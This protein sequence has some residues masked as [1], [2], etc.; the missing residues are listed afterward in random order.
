MENRIEQGLRL[1]TA[2]GE[3]AVFRCPRAELSSQHAD[4]TADG[5]AA[6]RNQQSQGVFLGTAEGAT[7]AKATL[8]GAQHLTQVGE[9][10]HRS[11]LSFRKYGKSVGAGARETILAGYA[12]GQGGDDGFAVQG[13]LMALG[14]LSQNFGDVQGSCRALKYLVYHVNLRHTPNGSGSLGPNLLP[15][16]SAKA[17]ESVEL[18]FGNSFENFNEVITEIIWHG[19]SPW[20]SKNSIA[21]PIAYVNLYTHT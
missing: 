20:T 8:P 13:G 18:C 12:L 2:L 3:Q 11:P 7:I 14:D 5:A 19:G 16:A 17:A 1:P 9:Q 15:W 4:A 21:K 6:K 10:C